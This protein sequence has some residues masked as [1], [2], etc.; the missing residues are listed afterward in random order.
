MNEP[1]MNRL[2][3]D[4]HYMNMPG[5]IMFTSVSP[6]N[7]ATEIHTNSSMMRTA[8]PTYIQKLAPRFFRWPFRVR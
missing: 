2:C 3:K 4:R 1:Y 6:V 5:L 7:S 8:T